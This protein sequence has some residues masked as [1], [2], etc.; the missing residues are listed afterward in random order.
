MILNINNRNLSVKFL[1]ILGIFIALLLFGKISYADL[2]N[3]R[4]KSV[5]FYLSFAF[6]SALDVK[7]ATD[8]RYNFGVGGQV[9]LGSE[10]HLLNKIYM[11]TEIITRLNYTDTDFYAG[12]TSLER[13]F[14]FTPS[15]GSNF[16][17][18]MFF[19]VDKKLKAYSIF[20]LEYFFYNLLSNN[21]LPTS[22]DTP[23]GYLAVNLGL[24]VKYEI[25]KI[26]DYFTEIT[27]G[28]AVYGANYTT[29]SSAFQPFGELNPV[30]ANFVSGIMIKI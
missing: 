29:Q 12:S 10:M 8:S 7:S 27:V 28:T 6:N 18:G 2:P 5:N 25:V 15:V 20:G 1:K 13:A 9:G 30:N 22:S 17:I 14:F 3:A 26:I 24:G 11:A 23:T 19:T 4:Q 21:T 16:K